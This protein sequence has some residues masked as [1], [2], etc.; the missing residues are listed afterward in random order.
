MAKQ[1]IRPEFKGNEEFD[2]QNYQ[3]NRKDNKK[4]GNYWLVFNIFIQIVFITISLL[5]FFYTEGIRKHYKEYGGALNA[6]LVIIVNKI[7]TIVAEPLEELQNNKHQQQYINSFALKVFIFKV[8]N[9]NISL[10]YTIYTQSTG[11]DAQN[12]LYNLIVGMIAVKM[13]N[14]FAMQ[15]VYKWFMFHLH[16]VLYFKKCKELGEEQGR[17]HR[18]KMKMLQPDHKKLVEDSLNER[19]EL[20]LYKHLKGGNNFKVGWFSKIFL[21][22]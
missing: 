6:V 12:E 18:I 22:C 8:I 10:I 3:V 13:L 15:F 11:S 20:F 2:H 14:L 16:K 7:F 17:M 21:K 5:I 1:E 9:T 19:K 4:T